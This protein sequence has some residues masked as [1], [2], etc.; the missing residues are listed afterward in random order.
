MRALL[1]TI[2]TIS[3]AGAAFGASQT[4]DGTGIDLATWGVLSIA[5][6]DTNT[7]FGD[8][9]N[10]LN[11]LFVDSD[12]DMVYM[13]IPGNLADNNA[14]T[15]LIDTDLAVGNHPLSTEPGSEG[16][17]R[18]RIPAHFAVLQRRDSFRSETLRRYLRRIMP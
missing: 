10:E 12:N 8:N 17:L 5:V 11:Q 14:L 9:Q 3:L 2:V 4:I 13:G 1:A 7:Q 6:Q 18:R 15:I 16:A